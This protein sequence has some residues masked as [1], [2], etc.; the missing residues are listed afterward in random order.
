MSPERHACED[1]RRGSLQLAIVDAMSHRQQQ[2]ER[3]RYA[4]SRPSRIAGATDPLSVVTVR[5]LRL[6]VPLTT[7][8]QEHSHSKNHSTERNV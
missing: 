3:H 5:E 4:R 6:C 1:V 7:G 2:L 8:I